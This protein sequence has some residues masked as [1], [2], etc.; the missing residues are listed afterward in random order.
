MAVVLEHGD[1][2]FNVTE[3]TTVAVD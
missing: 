1:K 3:S 2:A